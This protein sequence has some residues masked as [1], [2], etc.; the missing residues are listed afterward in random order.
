MRVH[1]GIAVA[2]ILSPKINNEQTNN[3]QSAEREGRFNSR[4]NGS[5]G[6]RVML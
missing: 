3:A 6:T 1:C 4:H 5:I 2:T